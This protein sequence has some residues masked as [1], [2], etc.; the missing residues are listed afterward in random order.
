MRMMGR[1]LGG[2]PVVSFGAPMH[3]PSLGIYPINCRQRLS[4][5]FSFV[6]WCAGSGV[7][8]RPGLRLFFGCSPASFTRV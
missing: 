1:I 2:A 7:R 4:L 6:S 8:R 5:P 3:S